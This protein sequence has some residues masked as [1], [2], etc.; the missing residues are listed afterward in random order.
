MKYLDL[1]LIHMP[2]DYLSGEN[3]YPKDQVPLTRTLLLVLQFVQ[4]FVLF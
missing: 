2:M 1:Y 4:I 3:K